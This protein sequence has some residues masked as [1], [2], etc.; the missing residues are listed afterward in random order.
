VHLEEEFAAGDGGVYQIVSS[1][2]N[3]PFSGR[4]PNRKAKQKQT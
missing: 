3:V 2:A 1:V 4:Y